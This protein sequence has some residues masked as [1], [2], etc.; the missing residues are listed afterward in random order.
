[1]EKKHLIMGTAGHVDHGKTT[2]IK[3]LTGF[4][5]D[6]H[7]QEKMRGITINLGFTHIDL[8]DGNSVSVVDVPGHAD[9]I[10]TMV[11]GACGM[12]FVLLVIAADEGIM[13][14]SKEHLEIMQHLG[15]KKG[16]VAL[17]KVDLVDKEL[18]ELAQEEMKEFMAGTFLADA[19]V[20]P[21][22]AVSKD[23]LEALITQITTLIPQIPEKNSEG[24]FRMFI[25]RIFSQPGFGTIVNGSVLAGKIH[26]NEPLYLLPGGR[27]VRVRNLQ[28]HGTD[29]DSLKAGDRGSLNLVNLKLKEFRKGMLLAS[30]LVK[31]TTLCDAKLMLFNREAKLNLWNQ[32]IFLL[33]TIRQ[34]VR[35]HL[36]DKDELKGGEASLVQIYLPSPAVIQ[37]DDAFIIRNSS[38]TETLGGGRII[39]PY[40]LHHRRRRSPQ[41][42]IVKKMAS[43]DP[44]ELLLA[45]VKK[46]VYPVSYKKISEVLNINSADLIEIIFQ[47]LPAELVFFQTENDIMLLEKKKLVAFQNRILNKIRDHHRENPLLKTG[48][49]VN[50]LLGLFDKDEQ[51]R[52][53]LALDLILQHLLENNKIRKAGNTYILFEHEVEIDV[54]MESCINDM[55]E[56][57]SE[58][59]RDF[60]EYDEI[61]TR[62]ETPKLTRKKIDKVINYLKAD[63]GIKFLQKK[64]I[65][66]EKLERYREIMLEFLRQNEAG[67]TVAQ[68][69]DLIAGNRNNAIAILEYFDSEGITLRKGNIRVLTRKFT[70]N[71]KDN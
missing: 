47:E 52:S 3:A 53:K 24:I 12:D 56:F 9:F 43:G 5:C 45:E 71:L 31:A 20:V 67:I 17:T 21:V 6:T 60:V 34:M 64:F 16:L 63:G 61:Y 58:K 62:F 46:A 22:S 49:T 48:K 38:G 36:L 57:F 66:S 10:K 23:G 28:R 41:I 15:L 11:T 8:P 54:E 25:D 33:G 30:R 35:I 7:A 4:D 55:K 69:R 51:E 40:P 59:G 65:A 70:N 18:L 42:E 50:E 2:L 26:R 37:F 68:F 1:M 32:V 19:P 29:V 44:V 14:Q 27:E 13:P 39:D